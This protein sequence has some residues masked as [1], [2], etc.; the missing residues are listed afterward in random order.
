MSGTVTQLV[1]RIAATRHPIVYLIGSAVTAPHAHGAPGVPR[2]AA[3][4]QHIL[5]ALTPE[6]RSELAARL[7]GKPATQQYQ[8]AFDYFLLN[9][10]QDATNALIRDCVLQARAR[11][12][13]FASPDPSEDELRD[14]EH[15]LDG[16]FLSPAVAA[17]GQILVRSSGTRTTVLTSNFDP[18]LTVAIRRAGGQVLTCAFDGEGGFHGADA[19]GIRVVHFHGDWCRTDTLH[20]A[21]AL[22]KPKPQ[23]SGFIKKLLRTRTLVVLG[24]GGWDDVVLHSLEELVE[25]RT[26]RFN[27]LWALYS[28]D[29]QAN[30][31][32]HGHLF[33]KF[34]AAGARVQFFVGVDVHDFL[35]KLAQKLAERDRVPRPPSPPPPPPPLQPVQFHPAGAIPV[36]HPCYVRRK[37]DDELDRLA[38]HHGRILIRGTFSMGKTSLLVR[39]ID[40][41]RQ[42]GHP[43]CFINLADIRPGLLEKFTSNFFAKVG[44]ALGAPMVDE[45]EQLAIAAEGRRLLL[46]LDEFGA[47][48]RSV[49][50]SFFTPL[51]RLNQDL[52]NDLG[53]V[54]TYRDTIKS[55]FQQH[56][57][58]H[59]NMLYGWQ[60]VA[61]TCFTTAEFLQL[62]ALLP[63][64]VQALIAPHH[65]TIHGMSEQFRPH[66]LQRL[67]GRLSE[68]FAGGKADGELIALLSLPTSYQ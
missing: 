58:D 4:I 54:V 29:E 60:D 55:L 15:D 2:V 5:E 68:A 9:R 19:D 18:L 53:L 32:E 42:N 16:W 37:S 1:N 26:D 65:A 48:R 64:P 52:S 41:W 14:L 11:A 31:R 66:M 22:A 38:P 63:A 27:V 39:L 3:V 30:A 33:T 45:W 51:L 67:F 34:A 40:Q 7:H 13:V 47:P 49:A 8:I 57:L 6:E 23:L 35:P 36:D 62:A 50:E 43:T 24:Y 20:T 61:L 59:P 10:G 56:G 44:K 12:P 25:E 46:A 17:L 28:A 21:P